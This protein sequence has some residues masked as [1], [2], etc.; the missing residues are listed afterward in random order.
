MTHSHCPR[1]TVWE[2]ALI[3]GLIKVERTGTPPR[4]RVVLT[5]QGRQALRA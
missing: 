3:D 5:A 1:L 2:D 4:G